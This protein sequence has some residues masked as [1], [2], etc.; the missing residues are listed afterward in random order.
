MLWC[1]YRLDGLASSAS[2]YT[3]TCCRTPCHEHD[4]VVRIQVGWACPLI[5]AASA[6]SFTQ[7]CAARHA[8]AHS[9]SRTAASLRE[10]P[11][12][13]KGL[14]GAYIFF[15]LRQQMPNY[16]QHMCW[17]ACWRPHLRLTAVPG[18]AL[19]QQPS[20]YTQHMYWH[21]CWRPHVR[22]TAVLGAPP[23]GSRRPR[24]GR[25]G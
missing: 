13:C 6:S 21:A 16:M 17:H 1:T 19:G 7:T 9:P 24:S 23:G 25:T 18:A 12:A 2:S 10:S 11:V 22:L 4:A 5:M 8:T 15:T 3:H 14:P 20:D